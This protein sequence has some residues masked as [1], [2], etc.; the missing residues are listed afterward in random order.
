MHALIETEG[1]KISSKLVNQGIKWHFIPPR[2]PHFGGLW[3]SAVKSFKRHFF[4][5]VGNTLMTFE[6][7]NTHVIEIEAILNSRPLTPMSTD[8]NDLIALTP[9]HFLIS[10]SLTSFPDVNFSE[11]PTNRLS[12]W[13]KEYLNELNTR[14]KW[15]KKGSEEFTV[16]AMVLVKEDN[17]P[18]LQWSIGRI[19]EVHPGN[20]DIVRVVSIKTITGI[21]KRSIKK[22]VLLPIEN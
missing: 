7:F 1:E 8:P 2:S 10:D 13:H 3:E 17:L 11:V 14:K 4:R 22:I 20:D 21:Y 5:T 15:N 16:G 6:D 9:G 18:P 12:R 19:V